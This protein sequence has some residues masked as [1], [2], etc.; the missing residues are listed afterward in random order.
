MQSKEG[1]PRKPIFML[2]GSFQWCGRR[3]K[4]AKE[5]CD[6]HVRRMKNED[7]E[8]SRTNMRSDNLIYVSIFILE[9]TPKRKTKKHH[10]LP[11]PTTHSTHLSSTPTPLFSREKHSESKKKGELI[12]FFINTS[13]KKSLSS[14]SFPPLVTH[15]LLR[16]IS[17]LS[18]RSDCSSE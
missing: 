10:H 2:V 16:T 13:S 3:K 7:D 5:R 17:S 14:L 15:N 11:L 4:G 12:S 6:C 8:G 1:E 18:S 9:S